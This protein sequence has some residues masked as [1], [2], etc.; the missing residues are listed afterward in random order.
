[1]ARSSLAGTGLID[2]GAP[3]GHGK[4]DSEV[5]WV[6]R[7]SFSPGSGTGDELGWSMTQFSDDILGGSMNQ[8]ELGVIRD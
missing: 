2:G 8:V 7:S 6:V 4:K 3:G 5:E 1:M